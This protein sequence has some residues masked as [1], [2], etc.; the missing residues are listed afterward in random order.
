[1]N[2]F[3]N[4][5]M[6]QQPIMPTYNNGGNLFFVGSEEEAKGWIVNPSQTVYLLDRNNSMLYIKSVEKNGM[7]APLESFKLSI[8]ENKT[9][10]VVYATKDDIEELKVQIKEIS[11]EYITNGATDKE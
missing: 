1:M 7:V 8:P 2:Y 3:N 4:P 9:P 6:P 5:Y 11:D 10:E